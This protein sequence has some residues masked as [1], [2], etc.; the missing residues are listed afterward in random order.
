M[1]LFVSVLLSSCQ[2]QKKDTVGTGLQVHTKNPAFRYIRIGK[3]DIRSVNALKFSLE[4]PPGF[5]VIKP[6]NHQPVFNGHPFNVSTA[7]LVK[8]NTIIMMHAEKVTDHS[9]FLNYSYMKPDSLSGFKFY[10]QERCVKVTDQILK[11]ATD[12]N[13]YQNHGFDFRPAFYMKQYFVNTDDGNQEWVLSF[14]QRIP[15]CADSTIN[16]S[17]KKRFENRIKETVKLNSADE[18]V[19]PRERN[20]QLQFFLC[21][22][23]AVNY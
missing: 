7:A 8:G 2:A 15:N 11:S 16:R 9:G 14:A 21:F 6:L 20:S 23:S 18:R 5:K 13:Y 12:L 3:E 4:I 1:V 10:S 22:F 19:Q 17:F